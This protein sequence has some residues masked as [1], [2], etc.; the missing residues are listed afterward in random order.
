MPLYHITDDS[1]ITVT[2]ESIA[3]KNTGIT[4]KDLMSLDHSHLIEKIKK[5]ESSSDE[6]NGK[7]LAE[8]GSDGIE[9]VREN[10]NDDCKRWYK[11][12][13]KINIISNKG[14]TVNVIISTSDFPSPQ[15]QKGTIDILLCCH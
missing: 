12:S 6:C 14:I 11:V 9:I 15:L 3:I 13:G 4:V 7:L 2:D 1:F 5:V 10:C 8:K